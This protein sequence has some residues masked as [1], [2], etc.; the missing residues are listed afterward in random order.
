MAESAS[1]VTIDDVVI[2]NQV[3]YESILKSFKRDPFDHYVHGIC[4]LSICLLGIISNAFQFLDSYS[5]ND[6][7]FNLCLSGR[8]MSK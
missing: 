6:A 5:T 1:N 4:G 7:S 3:L 8:T 2:D